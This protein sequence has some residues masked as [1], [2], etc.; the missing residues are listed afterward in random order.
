MELMRDKKYLWC[1]NKGH[2]YKDCRKRQAKQTMVTAAQALSIRRESRPK[3]FNKDKIQQRLQF[4]ATKAEPTNF[5][6]VLIK[7]DGHPAL[8]IVDF[9]TQG[10]DLID[11]KCVHLYRMPTRPYE[12]KSLTTTIKGSQG[13]IDKECT[14]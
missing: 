14:I 4:T 3:G 9:Q 5:S 8:A 10:G 2:N 11:S 13:T 12:K 1:R 7:A 6:K